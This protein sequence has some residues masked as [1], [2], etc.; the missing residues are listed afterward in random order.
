MKCITDALREVLKEPD[1]ETGKAK[2]RVIAEGIVAEALKRQP[3]AVQFIAN[4]IEGLP[5]CDQPHRDPARSPRPLVQRCGIADD[6]RA[7]SAQRSRRVSG[8]R[9]QAI[10]AEWVTGGSQNQKRYEI[11]PAKS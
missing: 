1:P 11:R 8:P 3:W 4:R 9:N 10:V 6:A 2:V 5:N 7:G